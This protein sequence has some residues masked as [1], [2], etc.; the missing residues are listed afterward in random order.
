MMEKLKKMS[1]EIFK[2]NLILSLNELLKCPTEE[3][4]DYKFIA[5]PIIEKGKNYNS[6]D[7]IMRL[8]SFSEKNIAGRIFDLESIV[9]LFSGLNPLYPMWIEVSVYDSY[10]KIIELRH[11]LRFRKPS[12]I[13]NLDTGH[14]PFKIM[15]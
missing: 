6:K 11:S 8:W 7:D 2:E 10:N 15:M 3:I 9:K 13:Q 14:P 4:T 1:K 12:E 5:T